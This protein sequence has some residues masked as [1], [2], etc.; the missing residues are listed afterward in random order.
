MNTTMINSSTADPMPIERLGH[1][2]PEVHLRVQQWLASGQLL[3]WIPILSQENFPGVPPDALQFADRYQEA[4]RWPIHRPEDLLALPDG[5]T[6][7]L[8]PADAID[9]DVACGI[10]NGE[11]YILGVQDKRTGTKQT[12]LGGAAATSTAV[13]TDAG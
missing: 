13:A 3:A 4:M 8:R 11:I 12:F 1:Y 5:I 10:W 2:D 9:T 7:W 6:G